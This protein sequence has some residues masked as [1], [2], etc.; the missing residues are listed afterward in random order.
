MNAVMH[1]Q[2]RRPAPPARSSE[3]GFALIEVIVSAVVLAIVALAVL[4]G[5]DGAA[6]GAA[7][8]RS[9]SVSA[10]IAEQDQERLRAMRAEDLGEFAETTEK[11]ID[12]ITYTIRS[13]G[14]WISD[15]TGGTTSCT[16][17]E[18]QVDYIKIST[19]VS[20][21]VVGR[22]T[23]PTTI[24]GL[25]APPAGRAR[26]T[27]AVQVVD[28]NAAP[29]VGLRVY[30]ERANPDT[31]F[32]TDDEVTNELGC[33]VFPRI[34]IGNYE[35]ELRE[36]GWVNHDGQNP[37]TKGTTVNNGAVTL[38]T[39]E[40][41]RAGT[42]NV[43]FDTTDP[44]TTGDPV[45]A[46]R[47]LYA[48]VFHASMTDREGSGGTLASTIGVG[49]LFPFPS[50]YGVHA[51]RCGASEPPAAYFDTHPGASALVGPGATTPITVRQP[52]LRLRVSSDNRT[53]ANTFTPSQGTVVKA[54][55]VDGTCSEE[56]LNLTTTSSSTTSMAGWV[57]KTGTYDPGVPFGSWQI[58]AQV[59]D[60]SSWRYATYSVPVGE[61]GSVQTWLEPLTTSGNRSGTCP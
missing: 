5:I 36:P 45:L 9:R 38:E 19:T 26:G 40:F 53:A 8:E 4:S 48:R 10:S 7:R 54:R 55:L 57:T 35:V 3:A 17:N 20:A 18:D 50:A 27:L 47:G 25:V 23:Q 58:C 49:S 21:N 51:G 43:S 56:Y 28:R 41:D 13:E 30:V 16:N 52:P 39:I 46:S 33:A 59:R 12:G 1:H 61:N 37:A 42:I 14:E 24:T 31:E 6:N 60:G 22:K 2:V 29:V 34:P 44:R 32:S 11:T 15:S